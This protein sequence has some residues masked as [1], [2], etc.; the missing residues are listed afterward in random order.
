VDEYHGDVPRAFLFDQIDR[1]CD[2]AA[3]ADLLI[4]QEAVMVLYFADQR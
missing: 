3:G 4:D 1:C 2:R